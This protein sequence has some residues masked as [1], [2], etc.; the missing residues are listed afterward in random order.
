MK[1]RDFVKI[2]AA[3]VA[4]FSSL[5]LSVMEATKAIQEFGREAHK[6]GIR[7]PRTIW[8]DARSSADGDGL[9]Q[10]TAFKT[11]GQAINVASQQDIITM[12]PGVYKS[13][14]SATRYAATY[15]R[16]GKVARDIHP[17]NYHWKRKGK[18]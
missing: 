9:T 15:D 5:G 3:A 14:T 1:R 6:A 11:I 17:N 12:M 10:A 4:A 7:Y 2:N 13:K 18:I 8:V 16:K